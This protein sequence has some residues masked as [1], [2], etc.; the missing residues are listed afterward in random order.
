MIWDLIRMLCV[1]VLAVF[2]FLVYYGA[3][4]FIPNNIQLFVVI[5]CVVLF[6]IADYFAEN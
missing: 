6:L 1:G 2:V 5:G 3:T 4:S